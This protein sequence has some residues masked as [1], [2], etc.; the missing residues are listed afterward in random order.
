[1]LV[2]RSILLAAAVLALASVSPAFPDDRG[3]KPAAP[4]RLK[5]AFIDGTGHGWAALGGDDFVNVNCD[6]DTWDWKKDGSVHCTGKPV[7]VCRSQKQYTNF[8]L[9]LEWMHEKSAGNSG[10]FVW[11]TKESLDALKKPGLPHGI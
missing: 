10:V 11:A 3:D 6:K 5:K 8:E 7:G 4:A 1:M 2:Y 9:V